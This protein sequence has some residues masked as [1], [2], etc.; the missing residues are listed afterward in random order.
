[1]PYLLA[2]EMPNVANRRSNRCTPWKTLPGWLTISLRHSIM[3]PS[4]PIKGVFAYLADAGHILGAASIVLDIEEAGR[5]YRF[6]FSG[7]IGRDDLPL[8]N[9]PVL[10][11]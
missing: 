2:K 8:I 10:P 6:W 9:D 3:K 11:A 7:D 1:M 5:S 4:P